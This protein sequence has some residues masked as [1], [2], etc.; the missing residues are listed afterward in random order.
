LLTTRLNGAAVTCR[1][2]T[3]EAV[4]PGQSMQLSFNLSKAAMFDQAN[5][6]RIA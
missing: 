6:E 3:R 5:G 1:T 2:H 4:K